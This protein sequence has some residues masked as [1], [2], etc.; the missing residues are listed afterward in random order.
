MDNI[1][2]HN[3]QTQLICIVLACKMSSQVHWHNMFWSFFD[4]HQVLK[5]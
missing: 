5:S 2:W 1:Y 4:H 3:R